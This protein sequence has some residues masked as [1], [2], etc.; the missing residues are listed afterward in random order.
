[1]DRPDSYVTVGTEQVTDIHTVKAKDR[2]KFLPVW[3]QEVN[4]IWLMDVGSR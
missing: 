2:N 1:M 4:T 3:K